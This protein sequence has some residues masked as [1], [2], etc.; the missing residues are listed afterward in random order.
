MDFLGIVSLVVA[1][2]VILLC[3]CA[4]FHLRVDYW[5]ADKEY[6]MGIPEKGFEQSMYGDRKTHD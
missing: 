3:V 5:L 2:A 1:G 4:Y 6:E